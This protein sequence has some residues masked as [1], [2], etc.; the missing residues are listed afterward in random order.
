MKRIHA[1]VLILTGVTVAGAS[2]GSAQCPHPAWSSMN[3]LAGLDRQNSPGGATTVWDP[4]GGGPAPPL[5]VVAGAFSVV[6]DTAAASIATWDGATWQP[7]GTGLNG[8]VFSLAVYNGDLIAAGSFTTAG[9]IPASN[10]ARWDGSSWHPLGTG[11]ELGAARAVAVFNGD[12]IAAGH[13]IAAGGVPVQ[14]IA[15]WDGTSWHP[16]GTGLSISVPGWTAQANALAVH[17]NELFVGGIFTAAGGV[18][19]VAIARWNGSVWQGVGGGFGPIMG[20]P[21]VNS[22]M[23]HNGEL[24]AGGYFASVGGVPASSI[25]R[26]NGTSWQAIGSGIDADVTCTSIYNGDLIAAGGFTTAGGGQAARIARWTGA[27]W[28]PLGAGIG[29]AAIDK[30]GGL[31]VYGGELFAVGRFL[32]AGSGTARFIAR[33][34]GTDWQGWPGELNGPVRAFTE[35][36]G[37]LVAGGYEHPSGSFMDTRGVVSRWTGGTWQRLGIGMTNSP[38]P[39]NAIVSAVA[40]YNGE[41]H[42]GGTFTSADGFAATNVAR[43]VGSAWLPVGGGTDGPV[44]AMTIFNGELVAGGA[45]TQA[46]GA[47]PSHVA[48]WNG[49][50]WQAIGALTTDVNALTIWNGYLVAG[51]AHVSL[52]DG[53]AWQPLGTPALIFGAVQ[54]LAVF[55]GDLIAGGVFSAMSGVAASHIARF[56]GTAWHPLGGG[57][58]PTT[59]YGTRSLAVY[60]GELIAGGQF[61]LAGGLP[62]TGIAAWNGSYWHSLANG[63]GGATYG[64]NFPNA[65]ALATHRGALMVGGDFAAADA[66]GGYASVGGIGSAF[67]AR[68]SSPLPFISA[69]QPGG[70]GTAVQIDNRWL[71]PG[72]EYFNLFSLDLCTPD[73]GTGPYGGLCAS[74]PG[75][76]MQQV[77]LPLGSA[78]FHYLATGTSASFGPF[79]L[80]AGLSFD[81]LCVDGIDLASGTAGCM[82]SVTRHTVY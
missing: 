34:N 65:Y 18:P 81:V 47:A 78:P 42:A 70:S 43:W 13:F 48:R 21:V 24:I 7:L 26:W 82:S 40:L 57:L 75:F 30:V 79:V 63:L 55:N 49:S 33:W 69:S 5:L 1:L 31:A 39:A 73:P 19:A 32:T 35:L 67:V 8:Y 14:K 3:K 66:S 12:L 53:A 29:S 58:T 46:S 17:G 6:G 76:L 71:V 54:A 64:T 60:G 20:G 36:A 23:S 77:L 62:A 50:T 37:D 52:W 56:D 41:I 72:H 27:S 28:Q 9:G 11:L 80:P 45:F 44:N 61:E 68:W 25:A 22:L 59:G 16:L 2:V 10:I 51:G 4:D 38:P 15:R 74:N